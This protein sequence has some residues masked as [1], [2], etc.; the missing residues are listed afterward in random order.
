M[1]TGVRTTGADNSS[2]WNTKNWSGSDGKFAAGKLKDNPYTASGTMQF[3]KKGTHP[4][5]GTWIGGVASGMYSDLINWTS[6]DEL[7]LL[8][9]L[10]DKVRGHS[11]NLGV[12]LAEAPQTVQLVATTLSRFTLAIKALRRGRIDHAMRTLGAVPKPKLIRKFSRRRQRSRE[13]QLTNEMSTKDVSAAWLELQYGW[14]PLVKD[15]YEAMDAFEAFTKEPRKTRLSVS[16]RLT[17]E[18][19]WLPAGPGVYKVWAQNTVSKRITATLTEKLSTARSLGLADPRAIVW[20]KIP[21]SFVADWFIPI[22]SYL[23][24]LATIPFIEATYVAVQKR[25]NVGQGTGLG[26]HLAYVGAETHGSRFQ[27][28]RTIPTTLT[29]PLPEFKP[30]SKSLSSGHIKNGIALLHQLVTRK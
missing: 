12:S 14:T 28:I 18:S 4:V 17:A 2:F 24:S 21:F 10:S 15:V 29:V 3:S 6:N 9:K 23:D 19:T 27:Y 8:A 16:R 26:S 30:W 25:V 1:T 13:F 7:A 11:F 22:G 5:Y 20:E